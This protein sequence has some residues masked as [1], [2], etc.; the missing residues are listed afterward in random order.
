MVIRLDADLYAIQKAQCFGWTLGLSEITA[1][2]YCCPGIIRFLEHLSKVLGF[3]FM[4]RALQLVRAIVICNE[5]EDVSICHSG[6]DFYSLKYVDHLAHMSA[7]NE[8]NVILRPQ[9][10]S[11]LRCLPCAQIMK[12]LSLGFL[13]SF[14]ELA[15]IK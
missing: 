1:G 13:E 11:P 15:Q 3:N 5:P 4:Y 10:L 7:L 8:T 2:V 9:H 14:H 12:I 6:S